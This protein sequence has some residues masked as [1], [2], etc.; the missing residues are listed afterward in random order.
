MN[1]TSE[2]LQRPDGDPPP[3]PPPRRDSLHNTWHAVE[4]ALRGG[5]HLL[6]RHLNALSG[7]TER[8]RD[9]ARHAWHLQRMAAALADVTGRLDDLSQARFVDDR[10]QQR[11]QRLRATIDRALKAT[12]PW[13]QLPR[14]HYHDDATAVH[15]RTQVAAGVATVL[16]VHCA[17]MPGARLRID[18][19]NGPL[20]PSR[21]TI[22]SLPT[23]PQRV[24]DLDAVCAKLLLPT[25]LAQAHMGDLITFQRRD[26]SLVS[27]LD[28]GPHAPSQPATTR[29]QRV[30][31]VHASLV[32]TRRV[33]NA[34]ASR[35][36][37]TA[38]L[39]EQARSSL[40]KSKRERVLIRPA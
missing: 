7:D 30:V 35:R 10:Q 26:G 8:D 40:E 9:P 22:T 23:H 15:D 28:F 12:G 38:G 29:T 4:S 34:S 18:V 24:V 5:T 3:P 6:N 32:R 2:R 36:A 16:R 25:L 33:L 27:R 37:Q 31:E 1:P 21:I 39:I 20:G 17:T 14:V 13:P 11:P 19:R